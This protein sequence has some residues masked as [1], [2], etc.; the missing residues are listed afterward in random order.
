[1]VTVMIISIIMVI[2]VPNFVKS[3]NQTQKESCLKNLQEIDSAKER[4][5]MENHIASGAAI[6]PSELVPEYIKT[7]SPICQSG[8]TYTYGEIGTDPSCS[9]HG[10]V[11]SNLAP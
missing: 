10:T 3:R 1:M 9:V 6:V 8:G 5:A 2:A 7:A 4:Y 11:Q